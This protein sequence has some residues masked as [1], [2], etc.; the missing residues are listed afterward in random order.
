[1]APVF[2]YTH[3]SNYPKTSKRTPLYYL[4]Q[5]CSHLGNLCDILLPQF[6]N[7]EQDY[8]MVLFSQ[9]ESLFLVS[10]CI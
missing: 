10:A 2:H 5:K 6:I 8:I 9:P 1:M 3:V 4:A 7:L